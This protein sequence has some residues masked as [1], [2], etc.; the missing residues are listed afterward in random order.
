MTTMAQKAPDIVSPEL[1][2]S[3]QFV[4]ARSSREL[5]WARFRQDRAAVAGLVFLVVLV[6]LA[7]FAP[8]I[9]RLVGHSP[10]QL[11]TSMLTSLGLP[12]GPNAHF[13]FGA[14]QVGRDVFIRTIYGA[15]T[16]LTVSV[17]GT[18]AATVL[19]T[20]SGSIAGY[21]GGWLDTV[22]SRTVDVLL[23]LPLLLF[24]I[25]LASVCSVS[26]NGCLAGTL[27]PGLSL[28][29]AIIALFTWPYMARIMRGQVI[30]LKQREFIEAARAMGA[31]DTR[32]ILIDLLPN[33]VAPLVVYATLTLPTNILFEASLSYLGL[34]VPQSTPSW[35][36]MLSDATSGS[37]FTYAWWMMVYPGL[38]LLLTTFAFN[39]VGDGFRD[40]LLPEAG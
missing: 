23:S 33:L 18:A 14:D 13:W 4:R 15:R 38:F 30:A 27:K 20:I 8:L 25:G 7:I 11:F 31:S 12:K 21:Y 19:G 9:A 2:A 35:G 24:A 29:M 37:L 3:R 39:L 32:I 34:G 40:A 1:V 26:A 28:V 36:R 17:V 10:N 5:L 6:L 22:I 16:S